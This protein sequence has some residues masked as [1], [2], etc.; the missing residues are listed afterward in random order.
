MSEHGFGPVNQAV[1][2]AKLLSGLDSCTIAWLIALAF[3]GRD[4][5]KLKKE[6]RNQKEWQDIRNSQIAEQTAKTE[7]LRQLVS[8][9]SS[10]KMIV[11]KLSLKE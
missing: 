8:E 6:Y 2:S 7:V 1:E 10:M 3:L 5:W 4:A 11:S 9:V